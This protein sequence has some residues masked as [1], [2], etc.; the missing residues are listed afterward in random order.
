MN[1]HSHTGRKQQGQRVTWNWTVLLPSKAS[2][3]VPL[4]SLV[5]VGNS[6]CVL[7]SVD[8]YGRKSAKIIQLLMSCFS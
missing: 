8:L 1:V 6:G 3:L 7:T 4:L 2:E 5:A